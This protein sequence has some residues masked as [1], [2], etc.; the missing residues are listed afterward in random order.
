MVVLETTP[1]ISIIGRP[2]GFVPI[3]RY[4]AF[5]YGVIVPGSP[6]AAPYMPGM[7]TRSGEGIDCVLNSIHRI[8]FAIPYVDTAKCQFRDALSKARNNILPSD[9]R[10]P[11]TSLSWLALTNPARLI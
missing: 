1:S 11:D 9:P 4:R 2:S 5:I 3:L 7:G 8:R 10:N 6:P